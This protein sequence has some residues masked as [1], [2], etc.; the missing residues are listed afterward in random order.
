MGPN[1]TADTAKPIPN[2][3][4]HWTGWPMIQTTD[5][6]YYSLEPFEM[7]FLKLGLTSAERINQKKIGESIDAPA[8]EVVGR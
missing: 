5:G 2:P 1:Y 6:M 4:I 7:L 8:E 3:I